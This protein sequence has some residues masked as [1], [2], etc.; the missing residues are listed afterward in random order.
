[1]SQMKQV[2]QELGW[3]NK[4]ID[5]LLSDSASIKSVEEPIQTECFH[6]VDSSEV[7]CIQNSSDSG[8][9]L[10]VSKS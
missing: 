7:I 8:S 5:F 6:F 9:S 4:L 10:E 3:S 1:M 2:L